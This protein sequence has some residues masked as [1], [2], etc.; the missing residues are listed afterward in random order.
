MTSLH[1]ACKNGHVAIVHILL[2]H[3]ADT[4]ITNIEG[5]I[6]K[7]MAQFYGNVYIA[8]FID[9]WPTLMVALVLKELIAYHEI[10]ALTFIDLYSYYKCSRS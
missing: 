9:D 4:S 10:E 7:Q 8:K 5:K 6:P 1:E 2:L 3:G